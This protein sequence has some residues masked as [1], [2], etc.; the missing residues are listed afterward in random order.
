MAGYA[1]R[2]SLLVSGSQTALTLALS[3][4]RVET[5]PA[6]EMMLVKTRAMK[7]E[8]LGWPIFATSKACRIWSR[9]KEMKRLKM[10]SLVNDDFF[11]PC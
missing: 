5:A 3:D 7:S 10:M 6:E 2:T 8:K 4:D 11:S 1:R 9:Q